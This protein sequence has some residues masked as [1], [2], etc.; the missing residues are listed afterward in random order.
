MCNSQCTNG[1]Q[2]HKETTTFP[3]T[4]LK[5]FGVQTW[6]LYFPITASDGY[7]ITQKIKVN[8]STLEKKEEKKKPMTKLKLENKLA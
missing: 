3:I 1:Q 2:S 7:F 8:I 6:F 5:V 4:A